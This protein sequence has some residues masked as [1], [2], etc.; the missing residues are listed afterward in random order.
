MLCKEINILTRS[1]LLVI[2]GVK[3]FRQLGRECLEQGVSEEVIAEQRLEGKEQPCRY[4]GE[5]ASAKVLW[6]GYAD[7]W[8]E[9]QG[10]QCVQHRVAKRRAGLDFSL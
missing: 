10:G 9:L 5:T 6:Q 4:L 1:F 3:I 8:E 2:H 7:E